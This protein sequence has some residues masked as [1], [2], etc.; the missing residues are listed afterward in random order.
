MV[1]IP[2]NLC[3]LLAGQ[4]YFQSYP[5]AAYEPWREQLQLGKFA[6]GQPLLPPEQLPSH[7]L[8]VLSGQVR[9]VY[10]P[11]GQARGISL[12]RFGVG[13]CL[14][15]APLLRGCPG[16]A[17]SGSEAGVVLAIP[18]AAFLDMLKQL[19][20]LA[21]SFGSQ[22]APSEVMSVLQA[23]S[24]PSPLTVQEWSGFVQELLPQA[25][26]Q[27]IDDARTAPKSHLSS[28]Y[29]WY[30]SG[31]NGAAALG[32]AIERGDTPPAPK[33]SLAL[34]LLGLP[35]GTVAR[36]QT[37]NPV[38]AIEESV[39]PP[40]TT[41]S[42]IVGSE[43]LWSTAAPAGLSSD[44][45]DDSQRNQKFPVERGNDPVSE[46][47]ACLKMIARSLQIPFRRDQIQRVIEEQYRRLKAIS[48]QELAV[49]LEMQALRSQ[50]LQLRLVDLARVPL[51][52]LIAW[53]EGHAVL[54]AVDATSITLAD[55]RQGLL[56][57]SLADFQQRWGNAGTVLL[58]TKT[59]FTQSQRFGL[60]WFWPS[61]QRYRVRL[62]E[63]LIASLVVQLFTLANPLIIQQVIDKVIGQGSLN[64]LNSFAI[65][66]VILGIFQG[67]LTS[68]RTYLF[69]DTTNRIDLKLGSDIIDHLLKLPLRYFERRPVG[70]LSSRVQELEKIR[71]FLTGTALTTVMDAMFS[72]IYILVM[73]FYSWFLTVV[74]LST[75]PVFV[76][77]TFFASPIVRRQLREKAERNAETQSQLVEVLSGIQTVKAQNIELKARWQ[78]Q[79]RYARYI[80]SGF[81]NINT[82]TTAS[83]LT[84]FF[85]QLSGLLVLWVGVYL[86][87]DN[88][89]SLG[90]LIAFRIISGYVTQPLLRLAQLWQ[91]FQETGLSLER[92][93][94]IVDTP[95]ESDSDDQG[96]IPMPMITGKVEVR[97]LSFR[98]G[99][100][101]PLQLSNVSL[102]IPAG[103]FVGIVGQSGSGK[104]TLMKLLPRL[105][106][107]LEGEILIDGYDISKVELYS[108][109]RQIGIVPQD[110]LLFQG[111]V[112]EN[113]SLTKPN[114]TTDEIIT[115][116]KIAGAHDFIMTLPLGY[117]TRVGER[118]GALS[119][120]Q[121]QRIAIARTVLQNPQLLIL[122]EATS[123]LDYDTERQV[124]INLQQH[125]RGRTVFFITHRLST[126]R[127]ADRI[128]VMDKGA[129][130]E[131]GSHDEL[132][133]LRGRYYC[134][135]RQQ[136]AL[137]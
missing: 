115:A 129:M 10:Q 75:V 58:A 113:I 46:A 19:P 131:Q 93:A 29:D 100:Q 18:A 26:V 1:A 83:S 82:S 117:N 109:R 98:F 121:R 137:N 110:S 112:E 101:G 73:F 71:S 122:D 7:V 118:G 105:Y 44:L 59:Q 116:S 89:M 57:L 92:L 36:R 77:I 23:Q 79:E 51:P 67:L 54:Y 103:E 62:I 107:P 43:S 127:H 63:V 14:G 45:Y 81:R 35:A 50:I 78:W 25:R 8:V 61:I 97:N 15:W 47:Q 27:L 133:E 22:A 123:A 84:G 65:L 80:A 37:P 5:A 39:S 66:L 134:L 11:V 68:L 74:A 32:I 69:A 111:T 91:N 31:N 34:R 136:D 106:L 64:N 90:Q 24:W 88:Q 52:A 126:V 135:Y 119:G 102:E 2:S 16:E 95:Q 108:L 30:V 96:K 130:V 114:A 33:G 53:E 70:E 55:P 94:D 41:E 56:K 28:D 9:V 76:G 60:S 38:A 40:P 6:V 13:S 85:N 86:V 21:Q 104:S 120:G 125:F 87:F 12:G 124:S 49:L 72:V 132:M 128:I 3:E 20:D 17:T 48:L 4:A 99:E 42:A